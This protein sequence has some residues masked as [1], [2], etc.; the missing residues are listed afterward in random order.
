MNNSK[1]Y[2][3]EAM[4]SIHEAMEALHGVGAVSRQT[5]REFDETCLTP[6]RLLNP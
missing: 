5:M 4:A 6:V 2:P 3:N 1:K